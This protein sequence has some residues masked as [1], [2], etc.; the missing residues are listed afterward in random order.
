[1]EGPS[2]ALL[3]FTG[4]GLA[5]FNRGCLTDLA[6]TH[7]LVFYGINRFVT[8]S[9]YELHTTVTESSKFSW[10]TF[11]DSGLLLVLVSQDDKADDRF[12]EGLLGTLYDAMV[13][14][15]GKASLGSQMGVLRKLLPRIYGFLDFLLDDSPLPGVELGLL[16]FFPSTHHEFQDSLNG[17]CSDIGALHGV[18]CIHDKVAF[19]TASW[20]TLDKHT[21]IAMTA[22]L[23]FLGQVDAFDG[24]IHLPEHESAFRLMVF[25]LF[26]GVIVGAV[27]GG[28]PPLQL[29]LD[30]AILPSW[31]PLSK[32][33]ALYKTPKQAFRL[34]KWVIAVMA[35]ERQF[36]R[37]VTHVQ[38][39]ALVDGLHPT[40]HVVAWAKH[41]SDLFQPDADL[42]DHEVQEAYIVADTHKMFALRDGQVEVYI[43]LENQVPQYA[44]KAQALDV[45]QQFV[46][47]MYGT[48]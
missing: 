47:H 11:S 7:Q 38:N 46:A 13:F 1:M 17:F 45:L 21:Q 16:D 28:E 24:P 15:L 29:V 35:C 36:N 19:A 34:H 12:N 23:R 33:L 5:L 26:P 37:A 8:Q 2:K 3:A 14:I 44:M 42:Q 40:K 10:K 27:C 4:G 48:A 41:S 20:W 31:D 30:E 22:Y 18:L 39:S 25:Q 43:M 32:T 9:G 6:S